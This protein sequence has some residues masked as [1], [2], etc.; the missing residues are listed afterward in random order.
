KLRL[1]GIDPLHARQR[2]KEA[3]IAE[4]AKAITFKD[5]A[6]AY[7]ELHLDSFKNIKHRAQWRSTLA[8][9][10]YPKIGNMTVADIGPAD[11]LHCIEPIWNTKRETA[12]RVRQRIER[13]LDYATTRQYR[14]G[15]NP[16]ALRPGGYAKRVSCRLC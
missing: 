2:Q 8:T 4:Q 10:A 15:D 6:E 1:E 11:V 14:T 3:L 16:A 9:Y 7:L 13:I 5:V 12:S